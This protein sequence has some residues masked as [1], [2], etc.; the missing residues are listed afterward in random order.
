MQADACVLR[1]G[2]DGDAGMWLR[3]RSF[4]VPTD[5]EYANLPQSNRGV[6]ELTTVN[7]TYR[8][9]VAWGNLGIHG[10]ASMVVSV[11][12]GALLIRRLN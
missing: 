7:R 9:R 2:L 12:V 10:R 4:S 5:E 11:P 6:R 8:K 3:Y 1:S